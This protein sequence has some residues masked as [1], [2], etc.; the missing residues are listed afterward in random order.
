MSLLAC[1]RA[2]VESERFLRTGNALAWCLVPVVGVM[3]LINLRR[4]VPG[5]G[6]LPLEGVL[7]VLVVAVTAP[8]A[9]RRRREISR[10]GWLVVA[11]FI[12]LSTYSA[13]SVLT[14]GRPVVHTSTDFSVPLAWTL[15]PPVLGLLTMVAGFCALLA[16]EAQVRPRILLMSG[17]A[18]LVAG[19]AA[20]PRQAAVHRSW[21]FATAMAG[22]ATIHVALL[23][24]AG[25]GLATWMAGRSR[26]WGLGVF[27]VAVTAILATQSRAG[28]LALV[29]WVFTLLAIRGLRGRQRWLVGGGVLAIA[30][31]LVLIPGLS[32]ALSFSDVKR[33]TNLESALQLWGQDPMTVVFGTGAGQ[34]WPW[35]AFDTGRI[36]APGSGMVPSAAGDLLLSPHSTALAI[37]VELGLVGASLGL[38]GL[39][40]V[41]GLL[42]VSRRDPYRLPVI[43]AV[44][45]CLVAFLF[46]TYL[47]K[48]FGISFLWWVAVAMCAATALP[49]PVPGPTAGG[50][51]DD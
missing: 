34:V 40:G 47:V 50:T 42:Y 11:S 26:V 30:L 8:W 36:P 1:G 29:A 33:A 14:H 46:D 37:L 13:A 51:D 3:Q 6:W 28:L 19:I 23:L 17:V 15:A 41:C 24:V 32:R 7:L 43:A 12:A 25:I 48:N 44:F 2:V 5:V 18:L 39:G 16:A 10:L 4:T 49:G 38:L 21:R 35:L 45:S 9:W 20:W 22:S 27:G 31:S